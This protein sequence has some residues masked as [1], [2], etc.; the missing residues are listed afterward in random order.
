MALV[1]LPID[2]PTGEVKRS[3]AS[4]DFGALFAPTPDG[5]V[6]VIGGDNGGPERLFLLTA[7]D[8][9][10]PLAVPSDSQSE[11]GGYV[12][13]TGVDAAYDWGG[14]VHEGIRSAGHGSESLPD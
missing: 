9:L 14:A 10:I 1:A 7:S 4:A 11:F 12:A 8:Q 2:L 13:Q 6:L 3:Y 5:D